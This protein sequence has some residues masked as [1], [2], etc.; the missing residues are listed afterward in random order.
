LQR[1][2]IQS[3]RE[4]NEIEGKEG[5]DL[6]RSVFETWD[7]IVGGAVLGPEGLQC[8]S[9]GECQGR[10]VGVGGLVGEHPHRGMGRRVGV[11]G[12]RGGT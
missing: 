10:K 2:Y 8:Y 7:L 6:Y 12:S 3:D 9:V 5:I 1:L 4:E 11:G